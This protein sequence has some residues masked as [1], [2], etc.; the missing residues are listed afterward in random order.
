M[1]AGVKIRRTCITRIK[2]RRAGSTETRMVRF[3]MKISFW[4]LRREILILYLCAV[5]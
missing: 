5:R 3:S 4:R 2:F 1:R